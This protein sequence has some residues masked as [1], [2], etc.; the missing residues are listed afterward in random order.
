MVSLPTTSID[1][2]MRCAI[3]GEAIESKAIE[4]R[5]LFFIC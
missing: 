3:A 2:A 1:G 5:M 4:K